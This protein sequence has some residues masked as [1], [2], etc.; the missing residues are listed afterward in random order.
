MGALIGYASMSNK[1]YT[2]RITDIKI[3]LSKN[4]SLYFLYSISGDFDYSSSSLAEALPLFLATT[5]SSTL[6]GA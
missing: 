1:Q 5:S 2:Q 6:R 4:D 3:R